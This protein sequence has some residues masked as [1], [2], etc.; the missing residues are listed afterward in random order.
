MGKAQE[1]SLRHLLSPRQTPER[2]GEQKQ[3]ELL[4]LREVLG[5]TPSISTF[6]ALRPGEVAE[7][8]CQ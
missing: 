8:E 4:E 2:E 6:S 3:M 5:G 7:G 1:V